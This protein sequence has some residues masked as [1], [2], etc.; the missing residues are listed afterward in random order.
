MTEA[1]GE[2]LQKT[3]FKMLYLVEHLFRVLKAKRD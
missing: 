3:G 1:D 2:R